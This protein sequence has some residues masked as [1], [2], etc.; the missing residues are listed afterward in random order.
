MAFSGVLS[1]RAAHF[2]ANTR[3]LEEELACPKPVPHKMHDKA[4]SLV[5]EEVGWLTLAQFAHF[6]TP[7]QES[8]V[9]PYS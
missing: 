8:R 5:Q 7:M 1:L 6:S 3:H 4:P 2:L 9:W